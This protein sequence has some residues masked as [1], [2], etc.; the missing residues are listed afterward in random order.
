MEG[1]APPPRSFVRSFLPLAL[2]GLLGVAVATWIGLPLLERLLA[3][4]AAPPLP[5]SAVFAAAFVQP[6]LVT[7]AAVAVGVAL[8]H[9]VGL[10]SVLAHGR[11]S[12]RFAGSLP[13]A[14]AIGA[15]LAALFVAADLWV[16]EPLL[17]GFFQAAAA[18]A[19]DPVREAPR[20]L[21][22][23]VLYGG[24]TEELLMRWGLVTLLAWGAHRLLRRS[25][26]PP[27]WVFRSAI[28]VAALVFAAGHLPAAAAV[29]P[30]TGVLV[31]RILLLNALAGLVFGWLYWRRTL[32]TAMV[33]HAS[34]HVAMFG[35]RL[36]GVV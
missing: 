6:A 9:R 21:A 35:V 20:A 14:V 28:V 5:R 22:L 13:A 27:D 34:V 4:A 2:P 26:Q 31:L 3:D 8:S 10:V 7:L 16:F 24:V 11:G 15:A 18:Q 23:G 12:D 36:A 19:A 25:G 17:P 33:A 32:E 1:T 29:A 30:L